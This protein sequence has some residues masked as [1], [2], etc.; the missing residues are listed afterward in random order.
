MLR[1]SL[2][3]ASGD[4]RLR[5]SQ[6]PPHRH[7]GSR[8][9]GEKHVAQALTRPASRGSGIVVV[10]DMTFA[11]LAGGR[12]CAGRRGQE[13][14]DS[15]PQ[16][17]G[18]RCRIIRGLRCRVRQRA[19]H[20]SRANCIASSVAWYWAKPGSRFA[21][22]GRHRSRCALPSRLRWTRDAIEPASRFIQRPDLH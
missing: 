13:R 11:R 20:L 15:E 8:R 9:C 2:R 14:A 3:V 4:S 7:L 22:E 12:R 16:A 1:Q 19:S 10:W 5:R 6:R 21:T 17:E 18:Q